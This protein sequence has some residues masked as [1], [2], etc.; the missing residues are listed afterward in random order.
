MSTSRLFSGK[1]F[2]PKLPLVFPRRNTIAETDPHVS[3]SA[4]LSFWDNSQ[5]ESSPDHQIPDLGPDSHHR[6][7]ITALVGL[8]AQQ[9]HEHTYNPGEVLDTQTT[10]DPKVSASQQQYLNLMSSLRREVSS[11]CSDLEIADQFLIDKALIS[12]SPQSL[13]KALSS[14]HLKYP[15]L[16]NKMEVATELANSL[17][18]MRARRDP[19]GK[20]NRTELD[21]V[22]SHVNAIL[23][24]EYSHHPRNLSQERSSAHY[25]SHSF[26]QKLIPMTDRPSQRKKPPKLNE[27]EETTMVHYLASRYARAKLDC[28]EKYQAH[29]PQLR[30]YQKLCLLGCLHPSLIT[31]S[32]IQK[33]G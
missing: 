30:E 19:R 4:D 13:Q 18:E 33:I 16:K 2:G 29:F 1:P 26:C 15:N 27:G 11:I 5:E 23:L 21:S 14:F 22:K 8:G 9:P 6:P 24:T 25:P 32:A 28:G 31:E 20:T 12:R 7:T 10:R 3:F 17:D